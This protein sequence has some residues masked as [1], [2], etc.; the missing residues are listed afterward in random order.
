MSYVARAIR[1]TLRQERVKA[2]CLA[3]GMSAWE[4]TLEGFGAAFDQT[5][6]INSR[7]IAVERSLRFGAHHPYCRARFGKLADDLP[8]D[9]DRA[10]A[11][12]RLKIWQRGFSDRRKIA[13]RIRPEGTP[14][15]WRLAL[16]ALRFL[17]AKG[18][19]YA[20]P[21]L[22]E[23]LTTPPWARPRPVFLVEAAE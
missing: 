15:T 23:A 12:L 8:D 13:N 6:V 10:L 14:D 7:K 5:G 22:R 9:I 3:A 17:R 16:I 21:Q 18:F 1:P 20:W 2:A 11:I 4:S 19:S